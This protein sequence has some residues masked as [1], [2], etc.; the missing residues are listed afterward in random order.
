MQR[1]IITLPRALMRFPAVDW[2]IDWREQSHGTTLMGV[3]SIDLVQLPRW[4]GTPRMFFDRD[5]IGLWRAHRLAARGMTGVFR[6][7]MRDPA[8]FDGDPL[9]AVTFSGDETFS[10]GTG[11]AGEYA[12]RTDT[13]APAGATEIEVNLS[14]ANGTIRAGQILS[15]NDWPFAVVAIDGNRLRVE[16][17]LRRAIPAGDLIQLV[18]TGLFEMAA[19]RTGNLAYDARRWV[20]T[21]FQLREWLR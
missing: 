14:T 3:Q 21:E 13:G 8:T 6:V 2:D 5:T 17:P 18:G 9:D 10:D 11:F 7:A 16:M 4:V 15:H 19:P 12:V 20:D 1:Q